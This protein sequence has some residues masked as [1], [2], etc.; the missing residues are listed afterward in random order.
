MA[1]LLLLLV[2]LPHPE[3]EAWAPVAPL[4]LPPTELAVRAEA[5]LLGAEGRGRHLGQQERGSRLLDPDF[6]GGARKRE[7]G[8]GSAAVGSAH[9][10]SGPMGGRRVVWGALSLGPF[11]SRRVSMH[12]SSLR[13]VWVCAG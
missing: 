11:G 10:P 9:V 12:M 2:A 6:H 3:P 7:C 1:G 8:R 13:T 4:L 5:S